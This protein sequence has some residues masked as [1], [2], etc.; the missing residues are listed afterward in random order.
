MARKIETW[1]AT[2]GRDK[3]KHFIVTEMPAVRAEK[4]ATRALLAISRSGVDLPEDLANAG[5]AA[6]A[7]GGLKAITSCSFDDAEPLLDEM[8]ACVTIR[9]DPAL[10][11]ARP[12]I[13]EDFEEM[14]TILQLRD[15][16]VSLHT[17]FSIAAE[18]GKL[19]AA[20]KKSMTASNDTQTSPS[21]LAS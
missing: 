7:Y 10:E 12:T 15:R 5:M 18:L 2:E 20:A 3:G 17:G 11:Y 8:M 13:D 6:I 14:A 19:G 9:P 21:T 4:W 16:V 1:V